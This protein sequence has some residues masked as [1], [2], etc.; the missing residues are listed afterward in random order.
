V[1]SDYLGDQQIYVMTD[2]VN[3]IDQSVIQAYYFNNRH[4]LGYG[5]GFFHTKN[6]YLDNR[7]HLF[8]DRFYGVQ[9]F[10]QRPFSTFSRLELSLSELF[11]DRKFYDFNDPRQ[12]HSTKATVSALSWVTDNVLWGY[13][14]PVNGHRTKV[15]LESGVNLF[16]AG[17]LEYYAA[18][19]DARRYW[20]FGGAFSMG[21]RLSGAASTGRTPKRYYLGGTTN[22]IG[23]RTVGDDVYDTRNLYF[24]D[25]VTPLRGY[26]YYSLEGD[27]Y[28]LIN[29]EFRFPMVQYLAM[30]FPLKVVLG[31]ITG[32]V[33]TDIGSAW[34]GDHFKGG[35]SVGGKDR[36]QDIKTGFGWGMRANLFNF[37]LLRWDV[38]W[39]T[40]FASVS[41]RPS[42]Y[43]SFGADF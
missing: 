17:D 20:H 19:F 43:F 23:S 32:A 18:S 10:V 40:D 27:R 14:G 1:F 41:D 34:F 8:S 21:L 24:A 11:I 15:T 7:D 5:G 9:S 4:R 26:P 36:L 39:S 42:Y 16:D 22:W 33:F 38:A 13:T 25:V 31:N 35:T 37:A 30:R 29:W 2:V 3:T 28:G 12:N 6:Y